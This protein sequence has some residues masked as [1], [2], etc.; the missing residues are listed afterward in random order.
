LQDRERLLQAFADVACTQS[1]IAVLRFVMAATGYQSNLMRFNHATSELNPHASLY[2]L[3]QRDVWMALR[4][5][6]ATAQLRDIEVP[7]PEYE[8]YEPDNT[9]DEEKWQTDQMELQE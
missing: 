1:G 8:N 5:L 7:F 4:P 3:A 6:I 2:H 9:E